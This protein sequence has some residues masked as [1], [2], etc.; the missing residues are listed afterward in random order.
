MGNA[1]LSD[2]RL[3]QDDRRSE[4]LLG[5]HR[6]CTSNITAI[7]QPIIASAGISIVIHILLTTSLL[8]DYEVARRGTLP[9]TFI[10]Q[11]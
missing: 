10:P 8:R 3:T 4:G 7:K 9:H 6:A 5:R 1:P 11:M 2:Y